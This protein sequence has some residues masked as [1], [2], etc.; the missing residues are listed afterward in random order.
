M[1]KHALLRI[2]LLVTNAGRSTGSVVREEDITD[3]RQEQE[4]GSH[5]EQLDSLPLGG[6]AGHVQ[7]HC[8]RWQPDEDAVQSGEEPRTVLDRQRCRGRVAAEA[9][10]DV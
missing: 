4:Q 2:R 5:S 7:A 1:L 9:N 10:E 6:G 8:R 3:S